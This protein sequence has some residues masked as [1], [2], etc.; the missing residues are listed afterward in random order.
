[1]LTG[2]L[3][4]VNCRKVFECGCLIELLLLLLQ[5]SLRAFKALTNDFYMSRLKATREHSTLTEKYDNPVFVLTSSLDSLGTSMWRL[6]LEIFCCFQDTSCALTTCTA[7]ASIAFVV[8]STG[9]MDN[10]KAPSLIRHARTSSNN[11][12][13]AAGKM[14]CGIFNPAYCTTEGSLPFCLFFASA[15]FT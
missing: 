11:Q 9:T 6:E 3:K 14:K 13:Y 15:P 2:N 12:R 4:C 7:Y 10:S 8:E 1:M 5:D